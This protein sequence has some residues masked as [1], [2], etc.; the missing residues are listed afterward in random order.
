MSLPKKQASRL[1]ILVP[2][3]LS[4]ASKAGIRFA[5]QWSQQQPAELI[6][7]HVLNILKVPDWNEGRYAAYAA[8]ER[9]RYIRMLERFIRDVYRRA[10]VRQRHT[11]CL[12]IESMSP[13]VAIQDY[14]RQDGHF[15][16]ICMSTKG[17]GMVK[18]V[19]GTH[20]GNLITHSK[21]PVL[22]VPAGYRSRPVRRVLYAGDMTNYSQ[23]VPAIVRFA[24]AL[25]ARIDVLHFMEDGEVA[26]NTAITE[27]VFREQF[28]YPVRIHFRA[29]DE[30]L[31]FARN[32]GTQIAAFKPSV[33][34]LF[35]DQGRSVA[36]R[37]FDR[38]RAERVSFALKTPLLAF[39]KG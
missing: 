24:S 32:L 1:R 15:D 7:V 29:T 27:K 31:S 4:A 36:E 17:A 30:S 3:D 37:I 19:F 33:V 6:F 26:L 22:A 18:R 11:S 35:T 21:V 34:V 5:I 14:C 12:L 39:P 28:G 8:D 13:D 9:K 20:T 25:N 16:Y 38:S 10:R 23:E 2:T